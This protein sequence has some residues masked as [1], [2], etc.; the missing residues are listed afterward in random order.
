MTEDEKEYLRI[1]EEG[2][3][4]KYDRI[5]LLYVDAMVTTFRLKDSKKNWKDTPPPP[6]ALDCWKA[7]DALLDGLMVDF[8]RV[9]SSTTVNALMAS[10]L[11]SII[12]RAA[13]I[14]LDAQDCIPQYLTRLLLMTLAAPLNGQKCQKWLPFVAHYKNSFEEVPME[15][16]LF[17]SRTA[18]SPS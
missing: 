8:P 1:L 14:Q 5:L 4:D 2:P 9:A 13:L 10:P 17:F 11:P 6:E 12:N 16:K 3:K 18:S 7:Y 15:I